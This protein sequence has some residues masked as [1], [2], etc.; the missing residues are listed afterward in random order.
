MT[1]PLECRVHHRGRR[2]HF[3]FAQEA[4]QRLASA[5]DLLLGKS[6]RGLHLIA[7]REQPLEMALAALREN[8]GEALHVERHE[9]CEPIVDVRIG[10]ELRHLDPTRGALRRRGGTP[11]EEYVGVHY[12]V[13]R[14]QLPAGCLL[15]L[16]QELDELCPA[17]ATH[18]FVVSGYAGVH[19]ARPQQKRR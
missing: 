9:R 11:T 18:Q 6:H 5:P 15:G 7:G 19:G 17:R 8:Y 3:A 4:K 1:A 14:A 10:I 16:A 12:C 13:L 2:D